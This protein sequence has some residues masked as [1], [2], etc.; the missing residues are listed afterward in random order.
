MNV[1]L[2]QL[3]KAGGGQRTEMILVEDRFNQPTLSLRHNQIVKRRRNF[4]LGV[5]FFIWAFNSGLTKQ[6]E[7]IR[8]GVKSANVVHKRTLTSKIV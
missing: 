3:S 5:T 7:I 8:K 2:P 4:G 6:A 1:S